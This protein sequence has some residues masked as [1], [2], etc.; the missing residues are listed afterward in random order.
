MAPKSFTFA[1]WQSNRKRLGRTR[2]EPAKPWGIL[3]VFYERIDKPAKAAES[4][5]RSLAIKERELG[6]NNPD[7]LEPLYNC[8]CALAAAN[9][10]SEAKAYKERASN[11][12]AA[13]S[14]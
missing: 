6:A 13:P 5:K 14:R 2:P 10:P 4:F 7:L 3:G 12:I 9:K 11:L 1:R 8:A